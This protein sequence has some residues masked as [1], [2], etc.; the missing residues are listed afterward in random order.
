[1]GLNWFEIGW[2]TIVI[3]FLSLETVGVIR[4]IKAKKQGVPPA[5][6]RWSFSDLVWNYLTV[7][8]KWSP[9]WALWV[10]RGAIFV[11]LLWLTEHFEIGW[12]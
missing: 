1:M 10:F 3:E 6:Q 9:E 2:V 7:R 12:F 8:N 4:D 11:G 5:E